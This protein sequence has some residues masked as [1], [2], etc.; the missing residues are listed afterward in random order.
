MTHSQKI[1]L[2]R[3]KKERA[4]Q[5][6][7][8]LLDSIPEVAELNNEIDSHLKQLKKLKAN[9]PHENHLA[10]Y[11]CNTGNYDLYEEYWVDVECF[12]CGENERYYSNQEEYEKKWETDEIKAKKLKE[13][14]AAITA[15]ALSDWN[16]I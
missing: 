11:G 13:Q 4:E 1:Q 14:M 15:D 5:K 7:G 3:F 2:A 16:E 12:D 6:L 9:C 8:E 10:W